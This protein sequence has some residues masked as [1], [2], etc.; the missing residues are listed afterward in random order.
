MQGQLENVLSRSFATANK[1]ISDAGVGSKNIL[2]RGRAYE[3][4]GDEAE[5]VIMMSEKSPILHEHRKSIRK[6]GTTM[7]ISSYIKASKFYA[8]FAIPLTIVRD[9]TQ[10]DLKAAQTALNKARL[11]MGLSNFAPSTED[12]LEMVKAL[13]QLEMDRGMK[14][15]QRSAVAAPTG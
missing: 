4:A 3:N 2:E 8:G 12:E 5:R 1:H 7:A 9:E 14:S 6:A 15:V 11:V 13:H 10:P